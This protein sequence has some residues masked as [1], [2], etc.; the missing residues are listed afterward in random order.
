MVSGAAV[1]YA[2]FAKGVSGDKKV[3]NSISF[4]EERALDE[5]K[6]LVSVPKK[7]TASAV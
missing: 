4:A 3:R 6:E 7:A 1:Q 5:Q 2:N